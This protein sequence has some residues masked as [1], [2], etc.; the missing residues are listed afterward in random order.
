MLRHRLLLRRPLLLLARRPAR[1][2]VRSDAYAARNG[3]KSGA[4]A[5]RN[6]VKNGAKVAG[7][8]VW[9]GAKVARSGVRYGAQVARHSKLVTRGG[10][11]IGGAPIPRSRRDGLTW[12]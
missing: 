10:A 7:S 8:D 9:R 6:G 12:G 2:G 11:M 4:Y 1:S 5:A 3:V